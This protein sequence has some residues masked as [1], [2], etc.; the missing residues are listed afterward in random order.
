MTQNASMEYVKTRRRGAFP[1][2]ID[3]WA[4]DGRYFQQIH[5][6]MIH[7]MQRQLQDELNVRNY[8][9]G[10][11]ASLQVF[12]R[13]EP[14]LHIHDTVDREPFPLS[15]D[16]AAASLQVEPGTTVADIDS[17]LEALTMLRG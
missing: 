15:Y 1:N 16:S 17:E 3:P 12:A 10:K 6:G 14:D 13:R 4:E 2:R 5:S 8:E 7:E 11:E 9:I